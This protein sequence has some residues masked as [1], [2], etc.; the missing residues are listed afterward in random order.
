QFCHVSA[1][2]TDSSGLQMQGGETAEEVSPHHESERRGTPAPP[3][4]AAGLPGALGAAVVDAG[5]AASVAPGGVAAGRA[6]PVLAGV[7]RV[8]GVVRVGV[9]TAV[10]V[11]APELPLPEAGAPLRW[12]AWAIDASTWLVG[13]N[14]CTMPS[15]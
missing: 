6:A 7:A 4:F 9:A 1:R 3:A 2:F 13:P 8:A 5:L 10:D 12:L 15:R 11:E 14:S